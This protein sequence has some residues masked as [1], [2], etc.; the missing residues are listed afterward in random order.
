MED[1][2]N[3]TDASFKT[4]V[5]PIGLPWPYTLAKGTDHRAGGDPD[6]RGPPARPATAPADAI[7]SPFVSA[8]SLGP[9]PVLGIGIDPARHG[10]TP[11]AERRNRLRTRRARQ[12]RCSGSMRGAR[13]RIRHRPR[14]RRPPWPA[15]SRR[16]SPWLQ[17]VVRESRRLRRRTAHAL[18]ARG[19][20]PGVAVQA[21]VLRLARGRICSAPC[22]AAPWPACPPLEDV[23]AAARKAFPGVILGGGMFAYFTE[24]NRKRPPLGRASTR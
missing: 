23:Y 16:R 8:D 5:R 18:G 20:R 24:L 17:V 14:R 4:Y 7:R 13:R 10:R 3:W 2:R 11:R 22:P 21:T 19:G 6:R 1:Q 9:V 12:T 15:R